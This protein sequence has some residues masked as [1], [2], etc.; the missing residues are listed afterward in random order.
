MS[1]NVHEGPMIEAE[2]AKPITQTEE[3]LHRS[4]RARLAGYRR[5]FAGIYVALALIAGIAGGALIIELTKTDPGPAPAWSAWKPDGSDTARIRHIADHVSTRYRFPD[6][7]QLV[8][9]LAGPPTV[10]AGGGDSTNPIPIRAIAVRPDTSTGKAEEDDIQIFDA[11][12]SMQY[13]LC[14]L[15]DSCS[16]TQGEASEARHSLLRRQA[17][18]LSLYTFKYVDGIGSVTVF[19]PP[20]PGGQSPGSAVFLRRSD[21]KDELSHPLAST[22]APGAPPIGQIPARELQT[23]NRITRPR[24]YRYEYTQAQDLSAVLVLDPIVL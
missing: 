20:P 24:L 9:A 11:S 13:V 10:T 3:T 21:V 5:R 4:E 1:E 17:L 8:V 16:I 2:P 23:L 12:K 15:G 22:I 6:G 19:L 14:G 7:D 18:E